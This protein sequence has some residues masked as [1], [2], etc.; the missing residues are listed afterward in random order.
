MAQI[1][2]WS[3]VGVAIQTALAAA[4]TITAISKA[5]PAVA[6]ATNT[7]AVG[8]IVFLTVAGM[9]EINSAVVRI[10]A[11]SGGS[12]TL[13]GIDS[14]LMGTF[15]SGTA[16]K[17]T[18]GAAAATFQDVN[19]SGGEAAATDITT[20]HDDTTKEIP[21]VKSAI[22]YSFSSL[23]D[24]SDPA[25]IELKKADN[26]K[27]TRS[28]LITFATGA[29]AMF[30]CYPTCPL[31]PAGSAGAPVTSPVTFKVTGPITAYAT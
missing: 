12:F 7:Y 19:G 30:N 17:V 22:N 20:I 3:K 8:D 10:S 4:V 27:G 9:T 11:A 6:T 28:V 18:F 24:P 29:R 13:E 5:N 15:A 23:W 14:T 21:G 31:F 16:Q 2:I 25:L 1:N 26:V